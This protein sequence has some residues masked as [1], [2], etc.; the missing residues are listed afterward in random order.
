MKARIIQEPRCVLLWRFDEKSAGYDALAHA[1]RA[2][3]LKIRCIGDGDLAAKV[4]DLCR[5]LPSP[6]FA[7]L[8]KVSDRP[9]MI[10]SGRRAGAFP[11]PR[12]GGRGGVPAAG[13]G[14]PYQQKLDAA[15]AFARAEQRARDRG[16][17]QS[18]KRLLALGL[19]AI[20]LACALPLT[21][22]TPQQKLYS[23]SWFDMF[24]TV[25]MVQGY[26]ASQEEQRFG[27]LPPAV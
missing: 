20:C 18:M 15:A 22:C 4:G 9:A 14:D 7:P 16:R 1:A 26:A 11:R 12:Q 8:I 10:V 6:A 13:H 27:A 21:A 3:K 23:A 5:G 17:G 25:T 19:A 2:Y 24:D